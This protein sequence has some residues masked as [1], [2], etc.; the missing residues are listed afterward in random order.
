[1]A[2]PLLRNASSSLEGCRRLAGDRNDERIT[3]VEYH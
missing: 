1:M 3:H 2:P